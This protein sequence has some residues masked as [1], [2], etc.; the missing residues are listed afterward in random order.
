MGQVGKIIVIGEDGLSSLIL[1]QKVDRP[2]ADVQS[3]NIC[4]RSDSWYPKELKHRQEEEEKGAAVLQRVRYCFS[5]IHLRG[6]LQLR[7]P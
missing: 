3:F 1:C 7:L 4:T 5:A 2:A 6:H